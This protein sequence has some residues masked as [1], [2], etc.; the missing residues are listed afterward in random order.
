MLCLNTNMNMLYLMLLLILGSQ[1]EGRLPSMPTKPDPD[2]AAATARWLVSLNFWG[3]LNT[4]SI[5]LG[6]APF[7]NVVSFSDGLPNEGSGIPYFYLT[8][9]DPTAR[10]ALK[11]ERASFTVSEYPLGT[12]GKKDPE[13]PA[14][15]KLSLTGKLKLVDE[16]TKEAKFARNALFSKHP[17][18]KGWPEDHDFQVFKLEI[19]NIFLIDWFG[20]PKPLTVEQYL[21][22]KMNNAGF[23]L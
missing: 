18:M 5:D 7:S 20:G 2:D 15:S 14:C 4:I 9:L 21:H 8:T 23:I 10:N 22:P 11:D 1:V 6:G 3:V 19:E 13:N 17:E 12:C 16:K